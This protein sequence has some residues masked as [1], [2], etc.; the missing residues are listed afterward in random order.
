MSSEATLK[1]KYG[2]WGGVGGGGPRDDRGLQLGR[3]G[4]RQRNP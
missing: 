3:M 4:D 1:L 2:L